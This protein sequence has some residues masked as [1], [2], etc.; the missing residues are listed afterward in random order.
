MS[1]RVT[2]PSSAGPERELTGGAGRRRSAGEGVARGAP[3]CHWDGTGGAVPSPVVVE[4][5]VVCG[6]GAAGA[7]D[8]PQ[9][10]VTSDG[11]DGRAPGRATG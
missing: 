8:A 10:H 2:V 4:Q 11:G 9:V 1:G 3:G 7:E 5:R 6:S